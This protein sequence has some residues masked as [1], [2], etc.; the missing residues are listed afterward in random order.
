MMESRMKLEDIGFYTLSDARALNSSMNSPLWRCELIL[1]DQC[2]FRC[3]YCRGLREDLRGTMKLDDAFNILELWC[4]DGLRNVRFS[5]GEPTVHSDLPKLVRYCDIRNVG[6]IAVSTN[7]SQPIDY[8][9]K[10]LDC[11]VNDFSISLDGGC[12]AVGDNM[13]NTPDSWDHVVEVIRYLSKRTYVTVGMVFTEDNIADS[14][15]AVMFAHELGVA[16]IRV[17]SAAQYNKALTMLIDLPDD[18]LNAHPI[19][20]YRINNYRAGENVRGISSSDSHK[21]KLMLDDMAVAGD[22]HFPCII[23]MREYGDPVGI[24]SNNMRAE[25]KKWYDEHDTF[26]DPICRNNCLDVCVDYNNKAVGK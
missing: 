22:Y 12:C 17:L 9:N 15:N 11:G 18:I 24:V 19:L 1:T 16:D 3:K 14:Y 4:N 23:Y 5:G 6:H 25:R 13:A 20:K 21:C 26:A 8:Y 7:G 2:N 10:L